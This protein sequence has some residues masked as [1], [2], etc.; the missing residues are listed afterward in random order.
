MRLQVQ[1]LASPSGLRIQHCCEVW[2][3]RG[4]SDPVLLWLW[5]RPTETASMRPLAWEISICREYGS[6]KTK[7][8]KEKKRMEAE[9]K[10]D[11]G[12]ASDFLSN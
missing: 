3:R 12:L 2:G 1:D 10:T 9:T 5:C 11:G 4:G 7:K 8:E 6:K